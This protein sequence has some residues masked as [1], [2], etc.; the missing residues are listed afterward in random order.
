[1]I[2]NAPAP[3]KIEFIELSE[4]TRRLTL[5][6]SR[7]RSVALYFLLHG[8]PLGHR[9][10][11]RHELPLSS[12]QIWTVAV[13]AVLPALTEY[14]LRWD[15]ESNLGGAKDKVERI[16]SLHPFEAFTRA[17]QSRRTTDIESRVSVVVCTHERPEALN[18]CLCSLQRYR[19]ESVEYLVIDNAP[20][21]DATRS[22]VAGYPNIRYVVEPRKGLSFARNTAIRVS[23]GDIIAFTDDDVVVTENWLTELLHP[24]SDPQVMCTTGLVVPSE[25]ETREQSLFEHWLSF[26]RGYVPFRC[27]K[28]WLEQ[29]RTGAPVWHIGAG[30]NMAIRRRAFEQVGFFDSRLGAG[31]SGCS[32][33]S[34]FWYRLLA[35]G[36]VCE[37][38]PWS[39][40]LHQHRVDAGKLASQMFMYARGHAAAL[41]VQFARHHHAGNLFR[42]LF[43]LPMYYSH[44]LVWSW[45]LRDWRPFCTARI[46]GH[47]AGMFY[48]LGRAKDTSGGAQPAASHASLPGRSITDCDDSVVALSRLDSRGQQ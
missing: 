26:N 33:D 11:N 21:T 45:V 12:E 32:E 38:V 29:F 13:E 8:I 46:R 37:Y 10:L 24:F 36:F 23:H 3:C 15:A 14:L 27:G 48:L 39:L 35:A 5:D 7:Y 17:L 22:L 40:V 41:L 25:M 18:R 47:F 19:H 4:P 43:T 1:M 34:E 2:A 9:F 20:K 44:Q 30:A 42:L 28:Q 31:A 16:A 6:D